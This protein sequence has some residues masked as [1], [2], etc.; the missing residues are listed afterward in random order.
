MKLYASWNTVD[1][2]ISI[3]SE[4]YKEQKFTGVYGLPRGGLIFAVILSHRLHIPMLVAPTK[5]CLIVDDI[6]DSGESLLHYRKNS[7]GEDITDYTIAT[8]FYKENELGV[9]PDYYMLEKKDNWV[10]FPWEDKKPEGG[11]F[12]V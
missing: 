2:F 12:N 10:V 6:C 1:D 9:V 5:G 7:S 4:K 11:L 3:V 8:M